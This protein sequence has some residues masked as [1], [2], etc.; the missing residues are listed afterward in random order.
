MS[1]HQNI[2]LIDWKCSFGSERKAFREC[3]GLC[4]VAEN[5]VSERQDAGHLQ[6][7]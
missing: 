7:D 2:Y 3:R 5:D 6:T 4:L 1:Q